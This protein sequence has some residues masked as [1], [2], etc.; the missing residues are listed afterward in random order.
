VINELDHYFV[1][2]ILNNS[3]LLEINTIYKK[4]YKQIKFCQKSHVLFIYCHMIK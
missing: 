3:L 4:A 2:I 1:L